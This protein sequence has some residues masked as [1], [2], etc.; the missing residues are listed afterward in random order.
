M[1]HQLFRRAMWRILS[2]TAAIGLACVT[3]ASAD[4]VLNTMGDD[5]GGFNN[6]IVADG[7]GFSEV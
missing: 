6:Y 1:A 7:T 3:S 4:V 2:A 5:Q